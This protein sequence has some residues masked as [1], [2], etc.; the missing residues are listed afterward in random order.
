MDTSL[1]ESPCLGLFCTGVTGLLCDKGLGRAELSGT[2]CALQYQPRVSCGGGLAPTRNAPFS[3]LALHATPRSLLCLLHRIW[4]D[5]PGQS[6]V[7]SSDKAEATSLRRRI[8]SNV[9]PPAHVAQ[10]KSRGES[11]ESRDTDDNTDNDRDF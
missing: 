3:H 5:K 4:D 6:T 11:D 7:W 8:L 2:S 10:D 9:P 1:S